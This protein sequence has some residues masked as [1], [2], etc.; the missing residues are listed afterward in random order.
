MTGMLERFV[1]LTALAGVVV[2]GG[3]ALLLH[4]T[5]AQRL[6]LPDTLLPSDPAGTPQLRDRSGVVLSVSYQSPMNVQDWVSLHEVPRRL[7]QAVITAE[8]QRFLQHGGVD[9][10][11]RVHAVF[12]NLRMGRAVRG[13]STI[14]EQVV[15]LLHPRPRT[16]W[17]RW[18]EGFEAL[19]LERRFDK[20]RILEFYLNQVPYASRRLGVVQAARYYFARDLE[21]LNLREML[22]LATLPRSPSRLDPRRNPNLL[23]GP[24]ERLALRMH[25]RRL[26]SDTEYESQAES[27]LGFHDAHLDVSA[28]HFVRWVRERLAADLAGKLRTTLD[29]GLQTKVELLLEDALRAKRAGLVANAAALVVDTPSGEILAWVSLSGP[30]HTAIDAVRVPRQPGSTLKPFIYA[31]ALESGWTAATLVLDAPLVDAIGTGSHSY[32]NYSGTFYGSLRVREA[33]ANSLNT[34]AVRTIRQVGT[35]STL[36]KLRELGMQSLDR[37]A[38]FYGEGLALGNGEVSLFELVEAYATLGRGGVHREL[39]GELA[40]AALPGRRVLSAEVSALLT[41]ILSD[42]S[43]RQLEFHSGVLDLP[44]RTAV[45]TGTS[46]GYH[47]AW[48]LG[49]NS[50]YTVGVWFGN[51]DRQP[52]REVTGASGPARVLRAIYAELHRDRALSPVPQGPVQRPSTLVRR[53]ICALSGERPR[54]S[55]PLSSELFR[56]QNVPK[57]MCSGHAEMVPVTRA[58]V[59]VISRPVPGAHLALDPRIPDALERFE[60]RIESPVPVSRVEWWL[61]DRLLAS[62]RELTWLWQPA[63]GAHALRARV[64]EDESGSAFVETEPVRFHV[65]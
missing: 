10:W 59:A 43:A 27:P 33:L 54:A 40:P 55:C 13:A 15:R 12:Q 53:D 56:R 6:P 34:P 41:D 47:D 19:D 28:P 26:I 11:A 30:E 24:I 42:S 61:D 3:I 45:K 20:G 50:S 60:F 36:A 37:G 5:H 8:D 62:V 65:H 57:R 38:D 58:T 22:A 4:Q 16:L 64:F 48:S 39:T 18:L 49:T 1:R 9:W 21:T 23:D 2:M 17:S 25:E 46:S 44:V 35:A 32:R 63:R 52:M 31:L 29:G 51:L 7:I 14:T